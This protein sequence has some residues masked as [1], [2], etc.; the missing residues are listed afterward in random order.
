M[1][2]ELIAAFIREAES[3][4]QDKKIYK[5][6]MNDLKTTVSPLRILFLELLK[7]AIKEAAWRAFLNFADS[8]RNT[9]D[10]LQDVAEDV[11]NIG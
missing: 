4:S 5:D 7:A 3:P 1:A 2:S 8:I 11:V 10:D 6:T 9:D